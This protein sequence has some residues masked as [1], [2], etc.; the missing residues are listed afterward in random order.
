MGGLGR[1]GIQ[2]MGKNIYRMVAFGGS[3]CGDGERV[4]ARIMML[5]MGIWVVE[6]KVKEKM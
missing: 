6:L 4:F 5:C 3:A 1:C 2:W